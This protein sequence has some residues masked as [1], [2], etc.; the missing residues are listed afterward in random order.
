MKE[1]ILQAHAVGKYVMVHIDLAEGI[2]KDR[3]GIEFLAGCGVD[4][5]ISTRSQIIRFAKDLHLLTVQR[6]FALDSKGMESIDD[7]IRNYNF[8]Y[9]ANKQNVSGKDT[10][11]GSYR[12]VW[13]NTYYKLKDLFAQVFTGNGSV[14]LNEWFDTLKEYSRE[15]LNGNWTRKSWI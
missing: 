9:R 10:P 3:A 2:G 15:I 6:F 5:I 13:N 1:K 4:G 11:D 8:S 14:P 12:M 7:A